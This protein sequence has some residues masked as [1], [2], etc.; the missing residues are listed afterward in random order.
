MSSF[1]ARG[2]MS[3]AIETNMFDIIALVVINDNTVDRK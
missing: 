1:L 2:V 3:I